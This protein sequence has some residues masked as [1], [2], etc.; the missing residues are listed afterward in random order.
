[1]LTNGPVVASRHSQRPAA[2]SVR[3]GEERGGG[4][5]RRALPGRRR[6]G[7]PALCHRRHPQTTGPGAPEQESSALV[8]VAPCPR[9][10]PAHG[11]QR[12]AP[13]EWITQVC[14]VFS[15]HCP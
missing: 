12:R 3:G 7:L 11:A 13:G 10:H 9:G 8:H 1:M 2:A 15:P 14:S 4:E 5:A 6:P